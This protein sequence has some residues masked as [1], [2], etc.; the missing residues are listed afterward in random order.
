MT[1]TTT[2]ELTGAAQKWANGVTDKWGFYPAAFAAVDARKVTLATVIDIA[3]TI[4]IEPHVVKMR[5]SQYLAERA[6]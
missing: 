6:A 2:E 4:G 3:G 1:R 5:R